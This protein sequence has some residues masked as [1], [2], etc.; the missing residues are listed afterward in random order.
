ME[1]SNQI[2]IVRVT[3]M[4]EDLDRKLDKFVTVLDS[5]STEVSRNLKT[6]DQASEVASEEE[7]PKVETLTTLA[8]WR[9]KKEGLLS[10]DITLI[11]NSYN[12]NNVYEWN[13]DGKSEHEIIKII[14]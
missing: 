1:L 9:P 11:Q 13:I 7:Q 12:G 14:Q 10:Q 3:K 2:K 5:P 8:T 6:L 4:I